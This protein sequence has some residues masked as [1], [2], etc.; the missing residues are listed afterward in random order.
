MKTFA[1]AHSSAI[2]PEARP[3]TH[4]PQDSSGGALD[5][6]LQMRSEGL[7]VTRISRLT[8]FDRKT[9]RKYLRE[10]LT[11]QYGPT[12]LPGV[13]RRPGRLRGAS[14]APAGSV[15]VLFAKSLYPSN[16]AGEP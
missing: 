11:P 5:D 7:S 8:G 12:C 14:R 3:G 6:I 9:D 10:P 13:R 4:F 1:Y 16:L 2:R 15:Q